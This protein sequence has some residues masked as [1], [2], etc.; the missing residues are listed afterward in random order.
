[1]ISADSNRIG[2]HPAVKDGRIPDL[3]PAQKEALALLQETATAQQVR[4]PTRQ[5]DMVF[6]N[7]WGVLHARDSYQDDD[8]VSRHLVRL[9]LRNPELGWEIPESMKTPWE[10]SFGGKAK[11]IVNRQYPVEPMPEYMESKFTNGSAAFI[12]EE[13]DEDEEML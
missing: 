2:P 12:M 10:S 4:L 1:M 3:L 9:W 11:K 6:I 7:N 13:S 8:T 5:G